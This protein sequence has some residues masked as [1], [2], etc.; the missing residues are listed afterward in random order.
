MKNID[1]KTVFDMD[2]TEE[3]REILLLQKVKRSVAKQTL[4]GDSEEKQ[5][6]DVN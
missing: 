3:I 6:E 4:L 2:T 1:N 5:P